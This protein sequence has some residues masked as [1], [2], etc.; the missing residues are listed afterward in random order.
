MTST[1]DPSSPLPASMLLAPLAEGVQQLD[2]LA[3]RVQD[4]RT[5]MILRS[6]ATCVQRD[7]PDAETFVLRPD[8]DDPTRWYL[9][10]LTDGEG[11][12]IHPGAQLQA[13]VHGLLHSGPFTPASHL[14][15]AESTVSATSTWTIPLTGTWHLSGAVRP[16]V[17][18]LD[19][20]TEEDFTLVLRAAHDRLAMVGTVRTRGD[21]D[22]QMTDD[23]VF[24]NA[25]SPDQKNLAAE[26]AYERYRHYRD[27]ADETEVRAFHD[28]LQATATFIGL[29]PDEGDP[30]APSSRTT[31]SRRTLE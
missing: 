16:S 14:M 12:T 25:L 24:D 15:P 29:D 1:P 20:L 7:F 18:D 30:P 21:F 27:V 17:I 10:D 22:A 13:E 28:A 5:L 31:Q 3:T 23:P 2:V 19:E 6:A 11:V 8:A 4:Q 9:G 26:M